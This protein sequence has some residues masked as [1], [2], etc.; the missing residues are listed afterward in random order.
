MITSYKQLT[1]RYLKANRKRTLLT[2]I[3]IVLS[4]ALI[5]A[6]GFFI[7]GMMQ[8]Q[9]DS[10]KNDYGSWHVS[11]SKPS[12]DVV[13]KVTN[14]PKV[15]RSG[16]YE[17][18]AEITVDSG[19][20]VSTIIATD[21]ALELLPC[22][23]NEGRLPENENEVAVEKWVL[24][25]IS[26]DAK[27]GEKIKLGNK[28]YILV[29]ILQDSVAS[30]VQGSGMFL[31]KS[32]DIDNKSAV[33]L[34]EISSKTNLRNAVKEL[35][36]LTNEKIVKT[37]A[38]G[39]EVIVS[40]VLNN[41]P[42]IDMEG[43]GDGK[44]GLSQFYASVAV[45]IGI[46]V[47][48]TIAVIY[49][50]F[51]ISIVERIKQFGL[52]RAIG[53]TPR[54]IRKIVL[55][56]ATILAV[57][58]VPLGLVLGIIAICIIEFVF[59]VI[60]GDSVVFM[61]LSI[62]PTVMIISV[63][64]GTIAIYVSALIPAF[65]AGRISPL[66]AINSRTSII[67]EKIKRKRFSIIGKIFKFEGTLASK[68]I[69]RNRKRYRVTVFSIV[70]S[71][72]LFITFKSFTD[73][74]LNI[75]SNLNESKNIHFAVQSDSVA[76]AEKR[77]VDNSIIN[78]INSL[79][80]VDKVYKVYN[81]YDFD[82]YI[83]KD[84]ETKEV[85]DIGSIYVRNTNINGKEKVLM[86]GSI[87]IYD[88]AA[89]EV[90]KK[91]IQSGS[92][93][94]S[95]LNSENGVI[96]INKN[97][98]YN[99]KTK[100]QYYGPVADIKVGDEIELQYSGERNTSE[101]N[102]GNTRSSITNVKPAE[103]NDK[104][105]KVKVMAILTNDPFD[106]KGQQSGPKLIT[107]EEMAKKLTGKNDIKITGLNI[108]IKDVKNADKAKAQ[109]EDA[110]KSEPSL[111]VINY[112]DSNRDTKSAILMIKI[113]VYGFVV[114]VSL[115]GSVNIINTLTT[116]IILRRKEFAALK[117][118][119]LTQKGLRKIIVLE[120]LL[121]GIVGTIYGSII[122]C[123][124]SYMMYRGMNNVRNFPWPVPWMAIIIAAAA[125]LLIGYLSVLAPLARINRE[126]LIEAVREDY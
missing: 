36:S 93:D 99:A 34:A 94:I 80:V 61:K 72:V 46:V 20:K 89:L 123:I 108:T 35:D 92:I 109:I 120:G 2:I 8:A 41:S 16:L 126:N 79:N 116:N 21:K 91:Y 119:G 101:I 27:I 12:E 97:R 38:K 54:Q 71:V 110:I 7:V 112:S 29:G 62:S 82:E 88:N 121:Y 111:T 64:V 55:R 44:S 76:S 74:T 47:I 32:N 9:T 105:N 3:G 124:L 90:S 52:L 42:L 4:V 30:Q 78:N 75:S 33:L 10:I 83:D 95:K 59:K 6:I 15:S 40:S 53:T 23:I 100:T 86:N 51:Q 60:G 37:D 102:N 77:F 63:I 115:I 45:I 57:I 98:I 48:A 69:K 122:S 65:F 113:L 87:N 81:Q 84:K 1:G 68:N 39:K 17:M 104:I 14:N 49:N 106:F 26:R 13:S 117:A 73:M 107:T 114:V 43:G 96:L 28:E 125:S 31:S 5:A 67:K 85:K 56:E 118:I 70:I 22:K 11:F 103:K 19:V 18:D 66:V 58:G 25:Y 24:P 50:S